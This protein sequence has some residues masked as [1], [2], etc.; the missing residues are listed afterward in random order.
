MPQPEGR[1]KSLLLAI[2]GSQVPAP[3]PK[4][5]FFR[6]MG[7]FSVLGSMAAGV[8]DGTRWGRGGWLGQAGHKKRRSV[9]HRRQAPFLLHCLV[10]NQNVQA[11][12]SGK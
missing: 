2:P 10:A 11:K 6:V 12:A 7:G 9:G 8:C 4:V 3:S 5:V 1:E